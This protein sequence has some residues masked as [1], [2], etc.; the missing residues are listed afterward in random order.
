MTASSSN[1]GKNLSNI[2]YAITNKINIRLI[3]IHIIRKTIPYKTVENLTKLV[4]TAAAYVVLTGAASI[5][6]SPTR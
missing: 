4:S 2:E 5:P 6:S 3:N 1:A